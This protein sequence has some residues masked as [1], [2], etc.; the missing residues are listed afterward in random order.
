MK[1]SSIIEE[2]NK[3]DEAKM[4]KASNR[5]TFNHTNRI[6]LVIPDKS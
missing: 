3:E 2:K 4:R 6:S 5:F 1:K